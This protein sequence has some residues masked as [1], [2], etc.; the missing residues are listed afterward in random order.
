MLKNKSYLAKG[1][2]SIVYQGIFQGKKAVMK[3]INKTAPPNVIK[4][5]AKWL[6]KLKKYKIGPQ[7]YQ[8]GE[9]YIICEFIEGKKI[10][11]WFK[12]NDK[13]EIK[14]I[15]KEILK[16]CRILDNLRVNKKE[17]QRPVKHI[18]IGKK[19]KMIDF[20]RCKETEHPKNVTQFCQFL[21]SKN[22]EDILK[23]KNIQINKN[24]LRLLLK[25]YKKE[26]NQKNFNTIL[27]YITL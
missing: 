5:E 3:I 16:Q 7:L 18:I 13:K 22:I 27:K 20:E 4:N 8:E 1:K 10:M 2:R 24:K 6:K 21:T 17:L 26:Q 11:D 25:K 15:T 23:E 19:I 12:E 9:D 14:K